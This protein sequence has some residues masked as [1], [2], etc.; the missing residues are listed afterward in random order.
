MY[1]KRLMVKLLTEVTMGCTAEE[2][3]WLHHQPSYWANHRT[4]SVS[5]LPYPGPVFQNPLAMTRLIDGYGCSAGVEWRSLR[6]PPLSLIDV[7]HPVA[8][9]ECTNLSTQLSKLFDFVQAVIN[10]K[11]RL[12]RPIDF[13]ISGTVVEWTGLS[14]QS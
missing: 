13:E 4:Q 3:P 14:M 5:T 8:V 6:T 7:E 9:V 11:M 2:V 12:T 10:L 1:R